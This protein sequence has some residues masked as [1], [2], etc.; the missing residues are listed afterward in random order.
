MSYRIY[1]KHDYKPEIRWYDDRPWYLRKKIWFLSLGLF[2]LASTYY[3]TESADL[4][5]ISQ[6]EALLSYDQTPLLNTGLSLPDEIDQVE[7]LAPGQPLNS[8]PLPDN[9]PP[10]EEWQTITVQPRENLSVIFDRLHLSP[11]VL[12]KVMSS[13]DD[14]K[15]LKRLVPGDQLQFHID[16]GELLGLRYEPDLI[17]TLSVNKNENGFE[18]R[19]T[20]IELESRSKEARGVIEDSLFLA[21][22]AAGLTDNLIM[23]FVSIFGWD[24]DFALNIRKGD[25]FKVIYEEKFKHG[26]KVADG[27]ILAAEFVNRENVY[28]AV[29]Y[30]T[31]DGETGFYNEE[32]YS[33]RKA[34]L[35]TPLKFSRISSKF[36]SQRKH[37]ILNRIRFHKG[38]DYAAPTGTPVKATGDGTV[39]SIGRN[40]GYGNLIVLRH[41]GIYNTAYAH[42]SRFAGG[43]QRGKK[44]KQGDIIGYV[45]STGLATGPHL[46]YEFRVNGVHQNPLTVQLPKALKIPDSQMAHFRTQTGFILAQLDNFGNTNFASKDETSIEDLVFASSKPGNPDNPVR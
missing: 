15:I 14:T 45:G 3:L 30:T 19:I 11:A 1:I 33:M 34:F 39:I 24:I 40:G 13:G 28:K 9:E 26:M 32:G 44:V 5:N 31:P 36:N 7:L 27:P 38:V 6:R 37:P 18:S 41:G 42:L 17:T 43:M 12:Y 23:R 4:E 29:R 20:K 10:V 21:G 2:S 35:R 25:G 22:Q 46:H 8:M 16:E